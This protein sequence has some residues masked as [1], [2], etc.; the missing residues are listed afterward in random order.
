MYSLGAH[1][2]PPPSSVA[3]NTWFI[4][5]HS[6]FEHYTANIKKDESIFSVLFLLFTVLQPNSLYVCVTALLPFRFLCFI[7]WTLNFLMSYHIRCCF[8]DAQTKVFFRLSL[9]QFL[10]FF[11]KFLL[12]LPSSIFF[13][14][15]IM[16]FYILIFDSVFNPHCLCSTPITYF[17]TRIEIGAVYQM[18]P[19]I[20]N[21]FW[22]D[23]NVLFYQL[24]D[25]LHIFINLFSAECVNL[26]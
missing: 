15:V 10:L 19:N 16:L 22:S 5:Y 21:Q 8:F 17:V 24:V 3:H 23:P 7:S 26:H 2:P 18:Q 25:W 13:S 6:I 12:L 9:L 11:Y 1:R 4:P 14:I 20:H